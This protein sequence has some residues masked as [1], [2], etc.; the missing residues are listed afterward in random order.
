M[1]GNNRVA[2][3]EAKAVAPLVGYLKS[4]SDEVHRAT[5]RSLYQLSRDP[6]NCISM[7]DNGVV[8]VTFANS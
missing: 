5:A 1:W 3:G 4:N 2:F 8:K 7:H 6:D